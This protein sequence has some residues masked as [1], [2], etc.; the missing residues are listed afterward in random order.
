MVKSLRENK[1]FLN[2]YVQSSPYKRKKLL[3]KAS[4]DEVRCLCE[5]TLNVVNKNVPVTQKQINRLRKHKNTIHKIAYSK[6]PIDK[7]KQLFV[8]KG[9]WLP[10]VISTVLGLLAQKLIR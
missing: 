4:S 5:A 8:Q 7:K 9:G 3:K 1:H 2:K 10:F 6:L